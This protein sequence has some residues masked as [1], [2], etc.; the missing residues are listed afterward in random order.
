MD[1]VMTIFRYVNIIVGNDEEAKA[2]SDGHKWNLNDIEEI[3]CKIS[4]YEVENNG[5]RLVIITQGEQPVIVA[6]NG[7]VTKYPVTKIPTSDIVDS[8]GAGDAFIGGFIGKYI[9]GYSV[10]DCVKSG[11]NAGSYII[12]QPG[13]SKGDSFNI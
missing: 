12:Q 10:E 4:T 7:V 2:F 13:M 9:L 11:I 1:S 3:A 8:N 6:N 5:H